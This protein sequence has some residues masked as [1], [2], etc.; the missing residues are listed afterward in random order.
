M[1]TKQSGG[2][3]ATVIFQQMD[4]S[5][6]D[7]GVTININSFLSTSLVFCPVLIHF[8]I[9]D[10]NKGVLCSSHHMLSNLIAGPRL[11]IEMVWVGILD[12]D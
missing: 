2:K 1:V 9:V 10:S 7:W 8:S 3:Q 12:H 5:F 4:S 11:L 6:L